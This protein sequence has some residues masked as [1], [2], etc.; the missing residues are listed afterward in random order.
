MLSPVAPIDLVG[1]NRPRLAD[2]DL[3]LPLT[4]IW[5]DD[6]DGELARPPGGDPATAEEA[7]S[8]CGRSTS[9]R[10]ASPASARRAL[11]ASIARPRPAGA[12]ASAARR[13]RAS[14]VP[15]ALADAEM[16]KYA[17]RRVSPALH[18]AWAG[19]LEP[20]QPHYYRVQGPRLLVEYDNTQRGVNH[21]HAVWRDP[22]G[23]FG[24]DVLAEHHAAH[25]RT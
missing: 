14:R 20:G 5:R 24:G 6:S 2:G 17:G 22:D 19:G 16:E 13:L 21:V 12:A 18:F 11:A 8:G 10:S 3:P 4:D 15:D 1:G 7:K 9:T 25:H 23:D